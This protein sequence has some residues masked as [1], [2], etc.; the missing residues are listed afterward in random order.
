MFS[1]KKKDYYSLHFTAVISDTVSLIADSLAMKASV[2][3]WVF[4]GSTHSLTFQ[5]KHILT[6][7]HSQIC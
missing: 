6:Y 7:M 3:K 2:Y 1:L 4:E 5:I